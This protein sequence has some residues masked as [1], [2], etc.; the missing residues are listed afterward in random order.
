[1]TNMTDPALKIPDSYLLY[2]NY[3][4]PFNPVTTLRYDLPEDGLVNI[5]VFD[6]MG[7]SVITLVNT[8]QNAGHKF[9]N[10]NVTNPADQSISAGLYFFTIRAGDFTQTRKMVLL[11]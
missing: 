4:N 2:Q 10:W 6:I 5:T 7:R 11:K 8:E 3:P 9:I 1:M